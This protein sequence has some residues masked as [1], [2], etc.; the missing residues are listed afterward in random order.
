MKRR[1]FINNS[2]WI[3]TGLVTSCKKTIPEKKNQARV[4][5]GKVKSGDKGLANVV[6][7]DGFSVVKTSADG[8]YEI[9][10]A[11]ES[12]HIF[13]SIPSGYEFPHENNLAKHYNFAKEAPFLSLIDSISE[14]N[15]NFHLTPLKV[16]D[17]KHSFIIWA[18][19]QIAN[20]SDVVKLATSV[21]DVQSYVQSLPA[22]TLIHGITV[23]DLVSDNLPL[24]KNYNDAIAQCGMPFFQVLGNHD[25]DID[26]GLGENARISFKKNY[27]PTYYSFNRGNVH[28][29]VLD[30]I[31]YS[32]SGFKYKGSIPQEQLEWLKKDLSFV[33]P[34]K[35]IIL[36]A[37][38]PLAGVDNREELYNILRPYNVHVMSGHK[39]Y[40]QNIIKD[41][42]FEHVHSA[43]CGA[44]W[45]GDVAIDGTPL[46]YAVYEVDNTNIK[47]HFKSVGFDK[48]YQLRTAVSLKAGKKYVQ[49]N[50]WNWDPN[51]K[52]QWSANGVNKGTLGKVSEFDVKTTALYKGPDLPE[53]ELKWIE[54][55]QT[56]HL[57]SAPIP[58]GTT[59]IK[60]IATDRFEN[61]YESI[62]DV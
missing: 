7:S 6:I 14:V 11:S 20:E 41:H 32:G 56:E 24:F 4:I 19:P 40:N 47:W 44:W 50:V 16:N 60:V 49:A 3:T 22:N 34:D 54:P 48:S 10:L 15:I 53:G 17:R 9:K 59:Q 36:C 25:I 37:H 57:F 13:V 45:T 31:L 12:K 42:V 30:N 39:H 38:I 33:S 26:N 51:W 23:G 18:D 58:A 8:R 46:G 29:V 35:L 1:T 61:I 55:V 28:Y 52:V 27:G 2:F 62:L 5:S 21:A 43:V